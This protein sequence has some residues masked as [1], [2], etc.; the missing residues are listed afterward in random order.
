MFLRV[1]C[2]CRGLLERTE[3]VPFRLTRN[4]QTFFTPFGVDGI[5]ITSM[6][7]AAQVK[8]VGGNEPVFYT[9]NS[10]WAH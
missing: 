4:L 7:L 2:I 3:P 6:A 10:L 1:L 5:F 8:L 9:L